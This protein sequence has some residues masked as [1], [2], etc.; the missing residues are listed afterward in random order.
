MPTWQQTYSSAL[1]NWP[2]H[3][4]V[5]SVLDLVLQAFAAPTKKAA[6]VSSDNNHLWISDNDGKD[7]QCRK[8]SMVTCACAFCF[9]CIAI[10]WRLRL[11]E[12]VSACVQTRRRGA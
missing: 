6:S 7:F 11:G 1:H 5:T 12:L 9:S 10:R 8:T 2:W 3:W 4:C